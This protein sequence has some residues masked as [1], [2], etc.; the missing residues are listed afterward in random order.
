[1][2][3]GH[4]KS[5]GCSLRKLVKMPQPK[6]ATAPPK[7]EIEAGLIVEE[8]I[9]WVC[10]LVKPKDFI[11]QCKLLGLVFMMIFYDGNFDQT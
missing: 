7:K 5:M 3:T 6:K 1:M 9:Q 10:F 11:H 8:W 2:H 4:E